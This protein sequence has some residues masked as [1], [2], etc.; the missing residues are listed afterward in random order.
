MSVK[1]AN[2]LP[3]ARWFAV[4]GTLVACQAA[5][6]AKPAKTAEVTPMRSELC[7]YWGMT[8]HGPVCIQ[9]ATLE[10]QRHRAQTLRFEYEGANV[11]R[12][13]LLNGRGGLEE[14]D[15]DCSEYRYRYRQG[16]LIESTGYGRDGTVCDH[17][18]YSDAAGTASLVDAWG[19]PSA[20]SEN[21]Y[22]QEKYER[23]AAGFS[24]R[25]RFYGRD[26]SPV[27]AAIGAHEFRYER[28]AQGRQIA[29]CDFD[30]RGQATT[31]NN[32]VHCGRDRFDERGNT[33]ETAFFDVNGRPCESRVGIHRVLN[34]YDAFG[35]NTGKRFVGL[36]GAPISI[37]NGS[38]AALRFQYDDR[39]FRTAGDC[40]DGSGHPARWR[41]G[42]ASWRSSPDAQGRPREYRYFDPEG[43]PFENSSGCARYELDR[44]DAGHV[45]EWR[46]FLA[47]GTPGQKRGP[48]VIRVE[49]NAQNL[50]VR[51]RF[52]AAS[53]QPVAFRGCV[54]TET[55]YDEFRQVTRSTCRDA[56]GKLAAGYDGAAVTERSYDARGLLLEKRFYDAARQ[57]GRTQ[58][59]LAREIPTLNA[60]GFEVSSALFAADGSKLHLTRYRRLSVNVAQPDEFWPAR[61]REASLA[62]I[63]TA[64]A[65]LL[66][67]LDFTRAMHEYGDD[68]VD[69]IHPGDTGYQNPSRFYSAARVVVEPLAIGQYSEIVELPFGFTLYQR[70]E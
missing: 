10:D 28:D 67:G 14:D 40:L 12:R 62:R 52:F 44:D 51:R 60:Q 7:S 9:Q 21:P 68:R 45:T 27:K 19:R 11:A 69:A 39:G 63:E 37:E 46:Y 1:F 33:V 8:S 17:T 23:N 43:N 31:N 47:N 57:P 15:D 41:E 29:F 54:S 3:R 22:T 26:G 58:D 20:S 50:E 64:R 38:C 32:D 16:T 30:E 49:L 25:V 70:T 24:T 34:E 18:L 13:I 35:N 53:A 4:L 6:P 55:E 2:P 42:N 36:N 5:H 56:E 65:K 66:A 48:A 61:T 59:G